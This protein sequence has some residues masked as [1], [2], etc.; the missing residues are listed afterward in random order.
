[1]NNYV[2]SYRK[3]RRVHS[4]VADSSVQRLIVVDADV[5]FC[6]DGRVGDFRVRQ[7]DVPVV[8]I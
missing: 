2:Y 7:H 4:A 1:M 8:C 5:F 3:V 6:D